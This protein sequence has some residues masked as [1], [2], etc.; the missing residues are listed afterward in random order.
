MED[1]YGNIAEGDMFGIRLETRRPIIRTNVLMVCT[2]VT[3]IYVI[4]LGHRS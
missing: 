4:V 2:K 1:G 3:T